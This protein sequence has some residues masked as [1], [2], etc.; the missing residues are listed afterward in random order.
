M[1]KLSILLCFLFG[2]SAAGLEPS[3]TNVLDH[4][5]PPYTVGCDSCKFEVLQEAVDFWNDSI[6]KTIFIAQEGEGFIMFYTVSEIPGKFEGFAELYT[7][8]CDVA[9]EEDRQDRP[10]LLAHEIGHC[11]GFQHSKN[12]NSIMF[13]DVNPKSEVTEEIVEII[14]TLTSA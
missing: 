10:Y 8:F 6:G 14:E 1:K 5:S 7:E 12:P 9:I 11:I 3:E 2:C 13:E 4:L